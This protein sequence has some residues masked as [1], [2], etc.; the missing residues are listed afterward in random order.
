MTFF[1]WNLRIPRKVFPSTKNPSE[2]TATLW[3]YR[4][5]RLKLFPS[6]LQPCLLFVFHWEDLKICHVCLWRMWP[7]IKNYGALTLPLPR[8]VFFIALPELCIKKISPTCFF[9][10]TSKVFFKT[11]WKHVLGEPASF[12]STHTPCLCGVRKKVLRPRRS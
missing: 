2:V 11:F 9:W 8:K 4:F 5:Q 1:Q 6:T 12:Y 10:S 3:R 7:F